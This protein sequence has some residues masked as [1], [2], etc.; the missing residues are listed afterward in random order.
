MF[1]GTLPLS[2]ATADEL[3]RLHIEAEPIPIR[4]YVPDIPSALEEIVMKVLSKEPSARYR[5]ADQLG[6]VLLRFGAQRDEEPTPLSLTPEVATAFQLPEPIPL[7]PSAISTGRTH[8]PVSA[9]QP[10][11]SS[12][13]DLGIDWATI[14]LALLALFMA[15]GAVMLWIRVYFAYLP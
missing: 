5:T 13:L 8:V 1:S 6:R 9:R 11:P 3:A 15:G 4:E 7:P 10:D 2:A 14:G 12:I